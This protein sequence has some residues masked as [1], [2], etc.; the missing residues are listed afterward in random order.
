MIKKAKVCVFDLG[1][2]RKAQEYCSYTQIDLYK[3]TFSSSR[4]KEGNQ[5]QGLVLGR[6]GKEDEG[7]QSECFI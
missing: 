3:R 6:R 2:S 1:A 7:K 4:S 5:P